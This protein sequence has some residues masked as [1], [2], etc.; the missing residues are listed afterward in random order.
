MR[1]IVVDVFGSDDPAALLKGLVAAAQE[2]PEVRFA[3]AGNEV[4]IGEALDACA[5]RV[6]YIPAESVITNH[7]DVGEAIVSMRDSTVVRALGRLKTDG[8]AVGMIAAGSTGAV[9][10]GSAVYLGRLPGVV[11]P[12]LASL[13]PT[14]AGGYMCLLDCGANVDCTPEQLPPFAVMAKALMQSRG[15]AEPAVALLSVGKEPGKGDTFTRAAYALLEQ[16]PVHFIGNIEGNEVLSGR[17]DI[18]LCDGFT[19]NVL[20]KGIEGAAKF[21]VN[22]MVGALKESLPED[23]GRSCIRRAVGQAMQAMD[24]TGKAGAVLLGVRKPILKVHGASTA[25]TMPNVIRQM[26]SL[27]E[28]GYTERVQTAMETFVKG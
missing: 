19:G 15:V 10:A 17:A 2:I 9:L 14:A 20:L 11:R 12:A 26:L 8:E 5:D 1:K 22:V 16:A 6:E 27:V 24:Y 25:E 23:A 13:L 18:V 3:V 28:S 21:A 4:L 7:H